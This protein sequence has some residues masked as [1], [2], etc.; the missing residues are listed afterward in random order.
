MRALSAAALLDVWEEGQVQSPTRRALLLLAAA[1]RDT[2]AAHLAGLSIG[3]RDTRLLSLREQTFGPRLDCLV[4]CPRCGE[5]L[6]MAFNVSDIRVDEE[7]ADHGNNGEGQDGALAGGGTALSLAVDDY[8]VQFRLPNSLDLIAVTEGSATGP[9]R[10]QLLERCL[11]AARRD[12]QDQP[13]D[14]LPTSV[15]DALGERMARVDPQADVQLAL[16]CP[17]CGHRWQATFD[18]VSFLWSELGTWARRTLYQVHAL[19]QAYGWREADI[20]AMSAWRRQC[21]LEMAGG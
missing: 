19:A 21:Y 2:P 5:R 18:I 20:L 13:V 11:L 17:A 3:Q 7:D 1:C 10:H 12:H 6:E 14:Q 16:E 8:E 9:V 4:T 15:V